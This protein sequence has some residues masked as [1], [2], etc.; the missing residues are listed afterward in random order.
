[1]TVFATLL[2]AAR[3]RWIPLAVIYVVVFAVVV[4]RYARPFL[5]ERALHVRDRESG[6]AGDLFLV[7]VVVFVGSAMLAV[8][9]TFILYG[10]LWLLDKVGI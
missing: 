7:A 2:E 1:M 10:V 8:A 6:A 3:W 4:T 5:A 9:V